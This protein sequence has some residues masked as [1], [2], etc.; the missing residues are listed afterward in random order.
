MSEE[1]KTTSTDRLKTLIEETEHRLQDLK[2]ELQRRDEARQH[3][4]IDHL[5]DY[6]DAAEVRL[7]PLKDL[8][9]VI[10]EELRAKKT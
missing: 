4:A 7:R 1:L 8:V 6:I 3:D 5:E 10:L 9:S 2:A